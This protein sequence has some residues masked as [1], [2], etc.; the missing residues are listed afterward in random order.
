MVGQNAIDWLLL[1]NQ[2]RDKGVQWNEKVWTDINKTLAAGTA[3]RALF[4]KGAD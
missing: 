3:S 1:F 2:Q 4:F